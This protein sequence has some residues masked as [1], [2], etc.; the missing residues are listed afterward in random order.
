LDRL[1]EFEA[2]GGEIGQL[3]SKPLGEVFP[4]AAGIDEVGLDLAMLEE[5]CLHRYRL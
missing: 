5:I 4:E 1:G 3:A 2:D